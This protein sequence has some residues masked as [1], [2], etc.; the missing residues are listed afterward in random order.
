MSDW[1][2]GHSVEHRT[3]LTS[4]RVIEHALTREAALRGR[5]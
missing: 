4:S 1:A 5:P 3:N 2:A